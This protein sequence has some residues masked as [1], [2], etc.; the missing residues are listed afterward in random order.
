MTTPRTAAD[1]ATM[2][3]LRAEIDRIDAAL[4]GLLTERMGY[5]DRAA[6]LKPGI[7]MPARVD[8]RVEEVVARVRA[9]SA[10]Q[11]FD[12]DLTEAL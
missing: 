7:G 6:E 1:C 4:V 2:A 5:I 11:G 9:A 12:A 8:A 10:G 3:E